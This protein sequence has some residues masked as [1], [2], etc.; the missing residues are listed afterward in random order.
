[1]FSSGRRKRK[2]EEK[3]AES[4][5]VFE[6]ERCLK[7]GSA[8]FLSFNF[9]ILVCDACRDND[10]L[11]KLITKTEMVKKYKIPKW[12]MD[13]FLKEYPNLVK[14]NPRHE[15]GNPMVLI[16]EK[17][18]EEFAIKFHGSLEVI[19]KRIQENKENKNAKLTNAKVTQEKHLENLVLLAGGVEVNKTEEEENENNS[20]S[21]NEALKL[22]H[23]KEIKNKKPSKKKQKKLEV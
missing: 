23:K 2:L 10:G 13:D 21:V 5:K 17:H 15:R 1:M 22:K 6:C 11:D 8:S 19:E 3:K 4:I 14:A 20:E 9:K 12:P 18:A 7:T 16:Y